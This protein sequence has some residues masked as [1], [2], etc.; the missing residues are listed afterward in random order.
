M[1]GGERLYEQVYEILKNKIVCGQLPAGARLPSR[2]E[3]CAALGASEK[4]VRR[5]LGMLAR[6][7]LI[8]VCQRRRPVVAGDPAREAVFSLERAE[9]LGDNALLK[10]GVLLCY[11][12]IERGLYRC[13]G[14]DWRIPE[15]ILARMDPDQPTAFWRLSKRLWRFFV[16]RCG[17]ARILRAVDDLGLARI[18]PLP[19]RREARAAYLEQ[20]RALMDTVRAGGDSRQ[21]PFMD[22]SGLYGAAPGSPQGAP[23]PRD[24]PD[25]PAAPGVGRIGRTQRRYCWVY[26][27]LLGLIAIGR[28]APGQRLPNHAQLCRDYGVS[29]DTVTRAVAMLKAQG[30][31]TAAPGRGTLVAMDLA[32]LQTIR[33]EPELFAWHLRRFLD[34]LELLGLTVAGVAAHAAAQIAPRDAQALIDRLQAH[35]Q[36]GYLY[37]QTPVILLAFIQ[38]HIAYPPLSAVYAQVLKDYQIGR[39]IPKLVSPERTPVNDAIHRQGMAAAQALLEGDGPAFARRAEALFADVR[40]RAIDACRRLGYWEAAMAVYDGDL[41]WR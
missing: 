17:N 21:V 37:Q 33:L 6:E 31:V 8:Q 3:L 26:M 23:P 40:G 1:P 7:G 5:A 30:V 29:V 39:S 12:V 35:W 15:A 24:E 36:G 32:G 38:E 10:T 41:L 19:G 27:D 28:Y 2:A 4:T 13:A 9:A 18:D 14:E 34:N 16:A 25:P 20:L 22:L 11:P